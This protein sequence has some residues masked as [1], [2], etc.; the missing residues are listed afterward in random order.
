MS[1]REQ[2]RR[3]SSKSSSAVHA[4]F[5]S[6]SSQLR[7]KSPTTRKPCSFKR[8]AA[9][10]LSTP[11]LMPTTTVC[12]DIFLPSRRIFLE[13]IPYRRQNTKHF[14]VECGI[15]WETEDALVAQLDSVSASDAEGCGFDPRR[16]HHAKRDPKQGVPFCVRPRHGDKSPWGARRRRRRTSANDN[17]REND[18]ALARSIPAGSHSRAFPKR[19]CVLLGKRNQL[20]AGDGEPTGSPHRAAMARG[21]FTLFCVPQ[22][23]REG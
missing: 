22:K 7:M 18:T 10:E 12:F 20:S 15:I 9:T 6:D 5:S 19:S 4:P 3:T 17:E 16:V 13:I 1:R 8:R 11:P 21:L 23:S 14:S 2:T